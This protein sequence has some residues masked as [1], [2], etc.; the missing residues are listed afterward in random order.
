MVSHPVIPS[1]APAPMG[2]DPLLPWKW[3]KVA[4]RDALGY[5][6]VG[7]AD[8]AALLREADGAVGGPR[9]PHR[10]PARLEAGLHAGAGRGAAAK[11][12]RRRSLIPSLPSDP[13]APRSGSVGRRVRERGHVVFS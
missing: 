11:S 6:A 3:K 5:E 12:H 13:L 8:E 7:S 10:R 9:A 1:G 4:L 2:P